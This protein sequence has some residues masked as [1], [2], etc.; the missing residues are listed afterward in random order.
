MYSRAESLRGGMNILNKAAASLRAVGSL[1]FKSSDRIAQV[2]NGSSVHARHC[3]PP[4]RHC[5]A[6]T[7]ISSYIGGY[8]YIQPGGFSFPFGD[9]FQIAIDNSGNTQA[10]WGK[11]LNYDTPR[12]IWHTGGR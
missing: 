9:Y 6:E 4:A 3:R 5:S 1:E 11:G 7:R 8:S 12:S 2:G 10:C